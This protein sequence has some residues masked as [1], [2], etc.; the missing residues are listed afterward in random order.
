MPNSYRRPCFSTCAFVFFTLFAIKTH[1]S[2]LQDSTALKKAALEELDANLIQSKTNKDSA[3]RNQKVPVEI[4]NSG[5]GIL[6]LYNPYENTQSRSHLY[7]ILVLGQKYQASGKFRQEVGSDIQ[8]NSYPQLI[9]PTIEFSTDKA[10]NSKSNFSWGAHISTSLIS[11]NQR[12]TVRNS[13]SEDAQ[14]NTFIFQVGPNLKYKLS[15]KL[16]WTAQLSAGTFQQIQTSSDSEL[17]N[18]QGGTIWSA[19]SGLELLMTKD[20]VAT[21]RYEFRQLFAPTEEVQIQN[22]NIQLGLGILW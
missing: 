11:Q 16:N 18:S 10:M 17:R 19:G 21:F 6:K 13:F 2:T 14:L 8:L 12:F 1:S 4:E 7:Q 3:P 22:E 20:T 9:L 5:Q 15:E